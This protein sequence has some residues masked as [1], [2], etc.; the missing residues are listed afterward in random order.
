MPASTSRTPAAKGKS[1][2]LTFDP[3]YVEW[4]IQAWL[5]SDLA[6]M[7]LEEL[8][9][10]VVRYV[11]D[12]LTELNSMGLADEDVSDDAITK[13]LTLLQSLD[14]I[15]KQ[16]ITPKP[17][18]P[19]RLKKGEA[20]P[21]VRAV[22][23]L[24][25]P[26]YQMAVTTVG[27][28]L[29]TQPVATG[30]LRPALVRRIVERCPDLM[31]LLEAIT[32]GGTVV[33]P[34]R[35]LQPGAP[36]RGAAYN[37]AL[38]EGIGEFWTKNVGHDL[39]QFTGPNGKPVAAGKLP[40]AAAAVVLQRHPAG[41]L[42][43]LDKMLASA[44]LL[45]LIWT[46]TQQVNEVIGAMTVGSAALWDTGSFLPNT[47]SWDANSSR[48][49]EALV[50][51][52]QT[53]ANGSGYAPITALRGALGRALHISAPVADDLIRTAREAGDRGAQAVVLHFEPDEEASYARDRQPLIWKQHAF[54][55][56]EVSPRAGARGHIQF[57]DSTA[58]TSVR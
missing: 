46:Y 4:L 22:I 15:T 10:H 43:Q 36:T 33:R 58:R 13:A 53:C 19:P 50:A 14:L 11:R 27:R 9:A 3:R 56:I 8:T 52:H 29:L 35:S 18:K 48:F 54:D 16:K 44:G 41:A 40:D 30:G 31:T 23:P 28:S 6:P 21:P 34:V 57:A 1:V 24:E 38:E 25:P 42:K 47:P 55:N 17:P 5:K 37:H 20:P 49:L 51:A 2:A 32:K 39:P 7:K 45:G 12:R 26:Y